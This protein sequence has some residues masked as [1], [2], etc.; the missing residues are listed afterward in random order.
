MTAM[1]LFS[2]KKLVSHI[3]KTLYSLHISLIQ[4]T[5]YT[6]SIRWQAMWQI[7]KQDSKT[8]GGEVGGSSQLYSSFVLVL[9][10]LAEN[11]EPKKL[12]LRYVLY[13]DYVILLKQ[14]HVLKHEH[15]MR[16]AFISEFRVYR[17]SLIT[18]KIFWTELNR[19]SGDEL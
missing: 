13:N 14:L 9:C 10:W 5:K 18:N 17:A 2:P 19:L 3:H 6:V 4:L 15:F 16:D 8:N 1:H 7:K 12:G 11:F